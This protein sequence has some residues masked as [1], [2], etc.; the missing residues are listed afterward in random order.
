MGGDVPAS[1]VFLSVKSF[2]PG[3]VTDSRPAG[4]ASAPKPVTARKHGWTWWWIVG[5]G[6]AVVAV[7][8]LV[9]ALRRRDPR[10]LRPGHRK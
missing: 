4:C 3:G 9:I 10:K 6:V 5:L 2:G 8:L 7:T 1:V